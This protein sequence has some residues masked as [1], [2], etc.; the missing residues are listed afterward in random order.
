MVGDKN[1]PAPFFTNFPEKLKIFRPANIA[2]CVTEKTVFYP[3]KKDFCFPQ[4]KRPFAP[5]KK[6]LGLYI[7]ILYA[8]A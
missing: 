2:L 4:K 7:I 8:C 1:Y 5:Q 3:R 6:A